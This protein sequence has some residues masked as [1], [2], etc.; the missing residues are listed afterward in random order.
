MTRRGRRS[1]A[2][3]RM[4]W[5][6]QAL[7]RW[8]STLVFQATTRAAIFSRRTG[9]VWCA[10]GRDG[11]PPAPRSDHGSRQASST[12]QKSAL[13]RD[14]WD[15]ALL[16]PGTITELYL[17]SR[18]LPDIRSDALRYLPDAPQP[19]GKRLPAM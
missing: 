11:T 19:G 17:A 7:G 12:A 5:S 2:S 3:R 15:A 10:L 9:A 4:A 13:A 1:R 6:G 18:G 16:L 14:L 8:T